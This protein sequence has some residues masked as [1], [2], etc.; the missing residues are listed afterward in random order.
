MLE[1]RSFNTTFI[2]G[3]TGIGKGTLLKGLGIHLPEHG[4]SVSHISSGDLLREIK[5]IYNNGETD[6]PYAHHLL[7]I[8]SRADI[9]A[10]DRRELVDPNVIVNMVFRAVAHVANEGSDVVFLESVSRTIPQHLEYMRRFKELGKRNTI[11]RLDLELHAPEHIVLARLLDRDENRADDAD[12]EAQRA[13]YFRIKAETDPMVALIR[14]QI[15]S[16]E[17]DS[18]YHRIDAMGTKEEVLAKAI[19]AILSS[20][21]VN[22]HYQNGVMTFHRDGNLLV[23][24]PSRIIHPH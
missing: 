16:G 1:G 21:R 17:L 13:R 23:P 22:S 11:T 20:D 9:E 24:N 12:K 7:G 14:Q 2:T 19:H 15:A 18:E 10:M 4:V 5:T 3:D 6:H 8:V